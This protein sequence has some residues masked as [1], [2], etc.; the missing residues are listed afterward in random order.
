MGSNNGVRGLVIVDDDAGK[1][2]MTDDDNAGGL[3]MADDVGVVQS[4]WFVQEVHLVKDRCKMT[5]YWT[6]KMDGFEGCECWVG[7]GRACKG[8]FREIKV[9]LVCVHVEELYRTKRT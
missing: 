5:M 2:G 6:V 9:L 8:V 1:M 7:R 4:R 3:V